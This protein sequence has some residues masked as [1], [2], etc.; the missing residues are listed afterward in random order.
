[1]SNGKF[2]KLPYSLSESQSSEIFDLVHIDVWGP[3]KVPTNG[4]FRYFLL[5]WMTAVE[6]HGPIC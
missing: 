2:T 6:Q 5:W 3:Y 1:M 4:K